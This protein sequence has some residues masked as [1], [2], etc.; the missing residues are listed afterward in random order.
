[1]IRS[2]DSELAANL[3]RSF[4]TTGDVCTIRSLTY[5]GSLIWPAIPLSAET[6]TSQAAPARTFHVYMH[7]GR[8][9]FPRGTDHSKPI[10]R[11]VVERFS[12][13]RL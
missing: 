4:G 9:H 10:D 1:M 3:C 2:T 12:P 8:S 7:P 13:T 6:A 5:S 11:P